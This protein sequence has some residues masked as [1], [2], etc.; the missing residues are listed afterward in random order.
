MGMNH[1]S[2]WGRIALVSDHEM[3]NTFGRSKK[4]NLGKIIIIKLLYYEG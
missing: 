1:L 3:I 2:A 4:M